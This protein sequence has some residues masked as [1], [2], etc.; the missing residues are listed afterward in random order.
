[1]ASSCPSDPDRTLSTLFSS[2]LPTSVVPSSRSFVCQHL[3]L[4]KVASHPLPNSS[5]SQLIPMQVKPKPPPV[6]SLHPSKPAHIA[7]RSLLHL[8]KL[9]LVRS[10]HAAGPVQLAPRALPK[11]SKSLLLIGATTVRIPL[12]VCPLAVSHCPTLLHH[13]LPQAWF[14]ASFTSQHCPPLE[15]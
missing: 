13:S 8:S 1:M 4:V 11:L 12:T 15:R 2:R 5:R 3:R 9:P 14:P 10:L 6:H 7:S